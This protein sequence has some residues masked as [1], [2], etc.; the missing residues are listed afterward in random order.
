MCWGFCCGDGWFDIINDLCA[1][2]TARVAAGEMPQVVATQVK[3]KTGYLR[4]HFKNRSANPQVLALVSAAQLRSDNTCEECGC[5][6]L[7]VGVCRC[8][9][10]CVG[11]CQCQRPARD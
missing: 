3:S 10:V 1:E 7:C 8:V 11:V 6:S 4:F 9:S 5:F 2:I